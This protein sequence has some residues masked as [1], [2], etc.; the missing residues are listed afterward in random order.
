MKYCS[1]GLAVLAGGGENYMKLIQRPTMTDA[2]LYFAFRTRGVRPV[3]TVYRADT[4]TS[5]QVLRQ[6]CGA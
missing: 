1:L 5:T 3:S 6:R 4:L 2:M